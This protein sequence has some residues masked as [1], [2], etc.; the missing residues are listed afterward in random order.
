MTVTNHPDVFRDSKPPK[1]TR[2]L[3]HQ[4]SKQDVLGSLMED[5]F[6]SLLERVF[7]D[8]KPPKPTRELRHQD[9]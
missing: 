8:S 7:R 4:D 6:Q 3:R 5:D 1:P 9:S 2:E